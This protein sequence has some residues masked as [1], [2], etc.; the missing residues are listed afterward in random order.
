[1]LAT[2]RDLMGGWVNKRS[3][4]V[5]G[6]AIIAFVAVFAAAYGIDS[7]LTTVHII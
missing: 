4:N 1:M 2:D 3:T 5:I 6:I 7:F